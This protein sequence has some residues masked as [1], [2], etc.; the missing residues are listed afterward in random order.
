[1][2]LE[3]EEQ[4]QHE[5]EDEDEEELPVRRRRRK[6]KH[7]KMKMGDESGLTDAERRKLRRDQ[8]ELAK[9]LQDGPVHT[10]NNDEGDNDNDDDNDNGDFVTQVREK[11]NQLFEKVAYTR[12][13]VLDAENVCAIAAKMSKKVDD[14]I[15]VSLYVLYAQFYTRMT[16][17]DWLFCC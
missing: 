17:E 5:E 16:K 4:Q 13:A 11:N 10:N 1:M 9:A 12:E 15:Q 14:M 6:K 8:R 7:K 2:L 3:E